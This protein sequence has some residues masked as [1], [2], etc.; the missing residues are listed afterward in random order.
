MAMLMQYFKSALLFCRLQPLGALGLVIIVVM[1]SCAVLAEHVTFYNPEAV[2]FGAM[3]SGPSAEHP[4]GTDSFGR[5][6]FTRIVYGART[7]LTIGFL[8]SMIGC[9]IGAAIGIASAY[10]GGWIDLVL[11]RFIDIILSFPI[12]VLALVVVAVM[13]KTMVLG[14][15]LNLVFA[16]AIPI[17]PRSCRVIRAATL[18]IRTQPYVD[19]AR[20]GGY[21]TVYILLRYIAPNVIAPFLVL[22]TAYIAQAILLEASLSFLGLGV[23]EPKPAW[24]L[25]LAGDSANFYN[26]APWMILFPGLAISLSVF[27]FNLFGDS[28][29]D[30]LDPKYRN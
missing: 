15:D 10:H 1:A 9:H 19:A 29:R 27:A 30:W 21:S 28:L 18:S 3:L 2:D 6:I 12:V 5:D 7:A 13:G 8:S 25:M 14:I 23:S 17:I 16:I 20:A 24:G 4:F 11:Q 26:E 22:L